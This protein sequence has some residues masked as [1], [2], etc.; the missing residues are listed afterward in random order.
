MRVTTQHK[1]NISSRRASQNDRV[2]GEQK[3]HLVFSR[4]CQSQRDVFQTHHR[5]VNSGQP[6]RLTIQFEAHSLV[7]QNCY[8]FSAEEIRNQRCVNPMVM[9]P[10]NCKDAIASFKLSQHLGAWSSIM[11][12]F[13]DVV[14][15]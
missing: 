8:A 9:I 14:A 4:T 12:F 13:R 6:K 7:N 5:V 11:S 3:L 15:G 2:V 10:K 1:V